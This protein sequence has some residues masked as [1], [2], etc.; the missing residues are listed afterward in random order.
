MKRKKKNKK[1]KRVLCPVCG[2]LINLKRCDSGI[3]ISTNYEGVRYNEKIYE[4]RFC[5]RWFTK[6]EIVY[7]N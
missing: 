4:C 5:E 1:D 3:Q 2:N 6:E 7:D